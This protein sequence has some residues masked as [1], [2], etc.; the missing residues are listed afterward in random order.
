MELHS[1]TDKFIWFF[2]F[3]WFVFFETWR[4]D[5]GRQTMKKWG[6]AKDHK[7]RS[8]EEQPMKANS[9]VFFHCLIEININMK[10]TYS[11]SLPL[12]GLMVF[13]CLYRAGYIPSWP[14]HSFYDVLFHHVTLTTSISNYYSDLNIMDSICTLLKFMQ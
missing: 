11:V 14:T 1:F 6:H 2:Y 7:R 12:C 3:S 8:K 13:L 4:E 9:F 10:C 5:S